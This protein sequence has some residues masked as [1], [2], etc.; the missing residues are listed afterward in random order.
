M[1]LYRHGIFTFGDTSEKS[2]TRMINAVSKAE[3]YIKKQEK[4][5]VA[6]AGHTLLKQKYYLDHLYTDIIANGTKGPVADAVYWT[7]QKGIDEA[8]NQVG[9]Q[10]TRA[11]TFVYEKI[12]QNMVDGVAIV[13]EEL[14]LA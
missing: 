6:K 2:Y 9:K 4:N 7:N 5:K 12:D 13:R 8:V 14:G 11:A 3:R 1:I 10:T